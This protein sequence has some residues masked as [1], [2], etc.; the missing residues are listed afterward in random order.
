MQV[1]DLVG[2]FEDSRLQI[3]LAKPHTFDVVTFCTSI[4]PRCQEM[5]IKPYTELIYCLPS[6]SYR[7]ISGM[8]FLRTNRASPCSVVLMVTLIF[9]TGHS[10]VV[11][12]PP[13]ANE[14]HLY[15][16]EIKIDFCI[17]QVTIGYRFHVK[18]NQPC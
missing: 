10:E 18:G 8:M 15:C 11:T 9:V 3:P 4:P 12:C 6:H 2:Y 13:D 5:T 7:S 17:K 1:A 16:N 14:I